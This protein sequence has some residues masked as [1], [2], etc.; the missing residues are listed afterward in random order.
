MFGFLP[1]KAI[2]D[3]RVETKLAG[4]ATLYYT[5]TEKFPSLFS[6]PSGAS[7]GPFRGIIGGTVEY[8]HTIQNRL[9]AINLVL[10]FNRTDITGLVFEFPMRDGLGNYLYTSAATL[11]TGFMEAEDGGSYPC[12]NHGFSAGGNVKCIVQLGDPTLLTSPTRIIM[13]DFTYVSKM[14]CRFVFVNPNAGFV[15]VKVKAFGGTKSSTNLYGDKYMGSWDFS[16]IF[17]VVA[18]TPSTANYAR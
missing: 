8:G 3:F 15:S 2:S 12:G 7:Q 16:N 1:T 9:N 13:T 5:E 14:N 18:G 10:T 4:S 17:Q 11:K 6:L